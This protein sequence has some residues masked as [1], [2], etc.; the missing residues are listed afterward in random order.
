MFCCQGSLI[1]F[2][3]ETFPDQLGEDLRDLREELALS[4][5]DSL[6]WKEFL[7]ATMDKN[8]I[9]RDDKI[10]EAFHHFAKRDSKYMQM[11][12]LVAMLGGE[13]HAQE[14]LGFVDTDGDGKITFDEFQVAIKE[15]FEHDDL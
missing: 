5:T 3:V 2:F 6:M 13:S 10:R 4:G 1:I 7:A 15:A 12:D 8:L 11:S 14:V 9:M